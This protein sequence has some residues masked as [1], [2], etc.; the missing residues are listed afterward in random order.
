MRPSGRLPNTRRHFLSADRLE[1]A[2]AQC[3]IAPNS[4]NTT[5][6]DPQ[7]APVGTPV[8]T[9]PP[10][11]AATQT[12]TAATAATLATVAPKTTPRHRS[13]PLSYYRAP[14]TSAR[15]CKP[16][17]PRERGPPRPRP[18]ATLDPHRKEPP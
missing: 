16:S 6:A 8:T 13:A 14:P 12:A 4:Q 1:W 11:P 10:P 5:P 18:P 3:P 9:E 2:T 7:T 15:P 17:R